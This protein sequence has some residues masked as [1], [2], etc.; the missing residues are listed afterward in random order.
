MAQAQ[1]AGYI[2]FNDF[3]PIEAVPELPGGIGVDRVINAVGV[4][5]V[6]PN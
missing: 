3:N 1:G 2:N 5:A 6:H 4:D